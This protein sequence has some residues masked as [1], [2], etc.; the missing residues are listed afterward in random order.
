MNKSIENQLRWLALLLLT[1]IT[2]GLVASTLT[3]LIH[4]IQ[5]LSFGN[6]TGAFSLEIADISPFRRSLAVICAGLVAAFGWYTLSKYGKPFY[7][8]KTIVHNHKEIHPMSQFFHGILQLV[9]V[10][11][12]SPLGREGASREVSVAL[13]A[14]WLHFFHLTKEEISLLLA[15]ASG[16]ALG[17]VYNAPLATLFF[18]L[19]NILLKWSKR[20]FLSATITSF[21]AVWTV[22]L[23]S[24]NEVQYFLKPLSWNPYLFVWACLFGFII[25]IIIFAYKALLTAI[26][27]R[28]LASSKYIYMV[29]ASFMLA[30]L[31]SIAFPQILGNGKAGLLFFLHAKQDLPYASGLL[32]AKAIAVYVTFYAGTYGGKI[33]PSMMMGGGLGL[34]AAAL[35]NSFLPN[36]SIAFAIVI[37]AAL[38]LAIINNIPN[39][40][41]FFLVEI[42]GQPLWNGLPIATAI[43][44]SL[45]CQKLAQQIIKKRQIG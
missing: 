9:T 7:T 2:A 29:V 4:V 24:G 36:I 5:T 3:V 17:A 16:A 41:I 44:A 33:A 30:A 19:E 27:K 13:T 15:C 23:I 20:N 1:G 6:H 25:A 18:I 21:M 45:A 22:R 12:G 37:G 34:L 35:W 32:V 8:I 26:P 10:S 38:F 40:A 11:M 14:S 43:L 42:T 31:L 39:T 28:H